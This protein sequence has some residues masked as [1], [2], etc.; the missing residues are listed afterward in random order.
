MRVYG[1]QTSNDEDK[2]KKQRTFNGYSTGTVVGD[3]TIVL[4][5]AHS[6]DEYASISVHVHGKTYSA[7]GEVFYID[8]LNDLALIRL[9]EKVGEPLPLNWKLSAMVGDGALIIG[10]PFEPFDAS[11]VTAHISSRN[12]HTFRLNAIINKGNSGSPLLN[13]NGEVIGIVHTKF[14]SLPE[15]L[16]RIDMGK[17]D[18]N[19]PAAMFQQLAVLE[20]M[21]RDIRNNLAHGMGEASSI[22]ALIDG[23]GK[24][25]L[26]KVLKV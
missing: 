2:G 12:N 9:S 1:H 21:S 20:K 14:N 22:E 15:L 17:A 23:F 24:T 19:N 11:L 16:D 5:C 18:L 8:P 7:P 4:T 26:R 10:F 25:K 13:L 6:V 3:G